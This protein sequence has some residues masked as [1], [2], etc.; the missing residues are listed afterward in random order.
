LRHPDLIHAVPYDPEVARSRPAAAFTRIDGA[1]ATAAIRL[2]GDSGQ[3]ADDIWLPRRD[4]LDCD[5][6]ACT[7]VV[8]CE[9]DGSASLRFGDDVHGLRPPPGTRLRAVYRTGRGDRNVTAGAISSWDPR[10]GDTAIRA[11]SN[12]LP[13]SGGTGPARPAEVRRDAPMAFH[14]RRHCVI[15][16]DYAAAAMDDPRVGQAVAVTQWTG[17]RRTVLVHVQ[18]AG[19]GDLDPALRTELAAELEARR[20]LG[21]DVFVAAPVHVPLRIALTIRVGP[22]RTANA[23]R[24]E[25]VTGILNRFAGDRL[26]FGEPVFLSPVIATAKD[27]AGVV[28]V[29]VD[30]FVR[31]G[32][33]APSAIAAGRIDLGPT[34]IARLENRPDAPY[35]GVLTVNSIP[36]DARRPA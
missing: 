22:G 30:A 12:P 31:Y 20:I 35:R 6:F 24:G 27:V 28:D 32:R 26:R 34:E 17:D 4:L 25:V 2:H 14:T 23:A 36:I 3:L 7:F 1:E 8:E 13:A 10:P 5:R 16:Q 11:V 15:P 33:D 9:D 29:K 21:S 19:G 18:P